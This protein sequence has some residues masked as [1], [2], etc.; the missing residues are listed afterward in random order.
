MFK[1]V[2]IKLIA[3]KRDDIPAK[4]KLNIAKS[5]DASAAAILKGG[6]NVHPVPTPPPI[7]EESNNN[8]NDGGNNQK[9][10]LFKRGKAISTLP[11]NK[12]TNQLPKP[13]IIVGITIKNIIIKA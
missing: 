9:L 12:G 6:Y 5:T 3:P 7:V 8:K 11:N 13:P 10:K 2:T 1:M 4:C